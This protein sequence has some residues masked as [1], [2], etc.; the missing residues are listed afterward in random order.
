M[1]CR[2]R[3]YQNLMAL[4]AQTPLEALI[5]GRF[6][7]IFVVAETDRRSFRHPAPLL[8]RRENLASA[9]HWPQFPSY[10]ASLRPVPIDESA[11][12]PLNRACCI[13]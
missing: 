11:G 3:N 9:F 5:A 10:S 7:M 4:P 6:V 12:G 13:F 2:R 8:R 1:G